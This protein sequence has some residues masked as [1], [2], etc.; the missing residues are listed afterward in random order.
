MSE[1]GKQAEAKIRQWLNRP[2]C[3]YSFDR[4]PDQMT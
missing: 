4:I 3:E 1:L 2:E